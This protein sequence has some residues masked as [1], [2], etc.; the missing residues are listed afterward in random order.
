MKKSING[1]IYDTEKMTTLATRPAY[2]NGNY[3]GETR[4]CETSSGKL[5]LVITSNGQDCYRHNG[6]KALDNA[7]QAAQEISGWQLDDEDNIDRLIELGILVH[8]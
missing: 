7:T 4:L 6:I 3:A 1:M 8:A 5:C 2:N